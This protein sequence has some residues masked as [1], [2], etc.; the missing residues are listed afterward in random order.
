MFEVPQEPLTGVTVVDV[1]AAEQLA[2]A[3]PFDPA[4]DQV[5]GPVPETEDAVPVVQNPVVGAVD[6]VVPLDEPQA[7]DTATGFAVKVAVTLLAAVM[8]TVQVGE[9]PVH[10]PVHEENV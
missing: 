3:P 7:P 1:F 8:V 5:Q 9:V 4:H 2:V 6:T 10:A